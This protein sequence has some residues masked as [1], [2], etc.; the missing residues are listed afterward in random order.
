MI[1]E[2]ATAP[3]LTRP[4]THSSETV[5][6]RRGH[7]TFRSAGTAGASGRFCLQIRPWSRIVA[8]VDLPALMI[9]LADDAPPSGEPVVARAGVRTRS[10]LAIGLGATE[11]AGTRWGVAKT[12]ARAL[13]GRSPPDAGAGETDGRENRGRLLHHP[14]GGR[15]GAAIVFP[16]S[17]TQVT[18][19]AWSGSVRP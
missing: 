18:R 16:R 13:L 14:G 2:V 15:R 9:G 1:A 6:S 11:T 5:S 17:L 12:V 3:R 4:L 19:S 10:T 8:G 7:R